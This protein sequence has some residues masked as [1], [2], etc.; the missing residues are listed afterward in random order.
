[1]PTPGTQGTSGTGSVQTSKDQDKKDSRKSMS[2]TV[3]TREEAVKAFR[4]P[5]RYVVQDVLGQGAY[6][7][8]ISA[9][10]SQTKEI[11][12]IK[13]I[14]RVFDHETFTKRTLREIRVLKKLQHENIISMKRVFARA[15]AKDDFDDLYLV[16]ELMETDLA[17]IIK[18]PQPLTGHHVQ[19]FVYQLLRGLKFLHSAGIIHR[20]IKPRN[21]LVN[22]NCDLKICDMGLARFDTGSLKGAP[23]M[24]DYIATRWYRAPEIILQWDGYGKAIDMWSVGC[25]LAELI[26]RKPIFPGNEADHQITLICDV[27]GRPS[28]SLVARCPH[29]ETIDFLD[30]LPKKPAHPLHH[31]YRQADIVAIDLLTKLLRFDPE[32]RLT[33]AECLK[34]PYLGQLHYPQDEPDASPLDLVADFP[35]DAVKHMSEED[36][37]SIVL[38]EIESLGTFYVDP[39]LAESSRARMRNEPRPPSDSPPPVSPPPPSHPP[40][41]S[42]L[43]NRTKT[44]PVASAAPSTMQGAAPSTRQS[45]ALAASCSE[46]LVSPNLESALHKPTRDAKKAEANGSKKSE[47]KPG[48]A[49]AVGKATGASASDKP[50]RSHRT[51]VISK[52]ALSDQD[53]LLVVHSPI[54]ESSQDS[55][56]PPHS[57]KSPST[58]SNV[59]LELGRLGAAIDELRAM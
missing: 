11:V 49:A 35:F 16:F 48:V 28:A 4:I 54:F 1:M 46:T 21:L 17:N 8:V 50:S 44:K 40:V 53:S 56:I 39:S 10:D 5:S 2:S 24:T 58:P 15:R 43:H 55:T 22:S 37:A 38:S 52:P 45:V 18:S 57:P 23:P 3:R 59:S 13:K 30:A 31:V 42:P 20:D 32:K 36:L 12:A 25:I 33:V 7:V 9:L 19:F 41:G 51:F 6:G 26:G 47:A 27:L 34:H 14:E 29:Q